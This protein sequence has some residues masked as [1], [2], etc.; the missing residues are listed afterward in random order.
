MVKQTKLTDGR[1]LRIEIVGEVTKQEEALTEGTMNILAG[2]FE[3]NDP[4]IIIYV[5]TCFLGILRGGGLTK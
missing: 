5:A 2:T 3:R 4:A 1:H